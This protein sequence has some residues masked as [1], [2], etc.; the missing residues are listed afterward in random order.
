MSNM[1]S[2]LL[3]KAA[4][5][6]QYYNSKTAKTIY[7]PI[8]LYNQYHNHSKV[9]SLHSIK[10]TTMTTRRKNCQIDTNNTRGYPFFNFLW[11]DN[12]IEVVQ[13]CYQIMK[14]WFADVGTFGFDYNNMPYARSRSIM[15]WYHEIKGIFPH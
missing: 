12:I 8:E 4:M 1:L 7:W 11:F 10:R 3:N 15:L 5:K 14:I 6:C 2:V 9:P 13:K